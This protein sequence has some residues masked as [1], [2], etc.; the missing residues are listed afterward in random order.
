MTKKWDSNSSIKRSVSS[1]VQK[2]HEEEMGGVT[3][4][5]ETYLCLEQNY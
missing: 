5:E 2:T 1:N 4:F 3:Q